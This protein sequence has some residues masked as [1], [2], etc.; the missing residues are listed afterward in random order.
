[1][2]RG[3]FLLEV[4]MIS[5]FKSMKQVKE[6]DLYAIASDAKL[7]S[8]D[9]VP[10]I[11]FSKRL[12]GDGIAFELRSD[13]IYSPCDGKVIMIA[14]TKHAIGIQVK[15]GAQILIH[16]GLET[17]NLNGKGLEPLVKLEQDIKKGDPILKIDLN[18]MNEKNINLITPVIITNIN[19]YIIEL[20]N[21]K[22]ISK[23]VVICK[24]IKK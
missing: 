4:N 13:T 5:L 14:N 11:A 3:V 9:D 15:N 12:I 16:C 22:N 21:E 6:V 24:I 19:D 8:L 1:M 10:D 23:E 7:I 20:I 17:V 2:L 18:L